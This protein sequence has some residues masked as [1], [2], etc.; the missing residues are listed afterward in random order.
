MCA[1]SHFTKRKKK[2]INKN[3]RIFHEATE[4]AI[5]FFLMRWRLFCRYNLSDGIRDSVYRNT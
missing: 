3:L 1:Q 5:L 4:G 2:K